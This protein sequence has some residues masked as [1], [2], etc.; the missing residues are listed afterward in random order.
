MRRSRLLITVAVLVLATLVPSEARPAQADLAH[1][2]W[3]PPATLIPQPST[4]RGM[5]QS[6]LGA[7]MVHLCFQQDA[8]GL[9]VA[10]FYTTSSKGVAATKGLIR[11]LLH[12]WT[13]NV[14][15][16]WL[17]GVSVQLVA[18]QQTRAGTSVV[19]VL[20]AACGGCPH[21]LIHIPSPPPPPLMWGTDFAP[22][23]IWSTATQ[24]KP[25]VV[26]LTVDRS[27]GPG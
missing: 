20:E 23:A 12:V 18:Y 2:T 5:P 22:A 24:A 27:G 6:Q 11:P 1:C 13:I 4:L 16:A 14:G 19:S 21:P 10:Y 25:R 9:R 7:F 8:G 26:P 3:L 17:Y 15:Q